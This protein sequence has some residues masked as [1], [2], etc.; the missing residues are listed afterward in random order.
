LEADVADR[1]GIAI[2]TMRQVC[3]KARQRAPLIS[4]KI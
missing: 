2:A 3:E 1:A 4:E